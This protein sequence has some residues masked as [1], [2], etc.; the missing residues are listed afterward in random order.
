MQECSLRIQCAQNISQ[1]KVY[2]SSVQIGCVAIGNQQAPL[3][4]PHRRRPVAVGEE[5]TYT[6]QIVQTASVDSVGQLYQALR[7]LGPVDEQATLYKKAYAVKECG[8][9][10]RETVCRDPLDDGPGHLPVPGQCSGKRGTAAGHNRIPLTTVCPASQMALQQ[11]GLLKGD[12]VTS[13]DEVCEHRFRRDSDALPRHLAAVDPPLQLLKEGQCAFRFT[14]QDIGIGV[15]PKGQR[16]IAGPAGSQLRVPEGSD[17]PAKQY[18]QCPEFRY[19]IPL[20]LFP[21]LPA[22][23]TGLPTREASDEIPESRFRMPPRVVGQGA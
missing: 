21:E 6:C 19:L 8:H 2:C 11:G 14:A 13:G 12:P 3:C 17:A 15:G 9:G 5:G 16:R 18:V 22:N 7:L 23:D 20:K 1:G 4:C 10:K